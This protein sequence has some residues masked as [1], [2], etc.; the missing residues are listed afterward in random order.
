MTLSLC[1]MTEFTVTYQRKPGFSSSTNGYF[2]SI[3]HIKKYLKN[4]GG[5]IIAGC[6]I[7]ELHTCPSTQ[8]P[9]RVAFDGRSRFVLPWFSSSAEQTCFSLS[10]EKE[11]GTDSGQGYSWSGFCFHGW[12]TR[13]N[14]MLLVQPPWRHRSCKT[15]PLLLDSTD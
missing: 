12:H 15:F 3:G 10:G 7:F 4:W 14:M 1:A 6:L 5:K 13:D 11:R 2:Y 8:T 9:L